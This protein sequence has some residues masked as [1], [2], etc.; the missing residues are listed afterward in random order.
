MKAAELVE[1]LIRHPGDT[2]IL[3][4]NKE[5]CSSVEPELKFEDLVA[6]TEFGAEKTCPS[7]KKWQYTMPDLFR[8]S[9]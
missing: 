6:V 1:I 4:W 3:L 5:N 8:S 7:A 9:L 2:R